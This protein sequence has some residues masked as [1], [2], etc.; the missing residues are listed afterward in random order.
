MK[1]YNSI[2]EFCDDDEVHKKLKKFFKNYYDP[3]LAIREGA[4]PD[5]VFS[6]GSRNFGKSWNVLI[7]VLAYFI[8]TDKPFAYVR[9]WQDDLTANGPCLFTKMATRGII[10]DLF[11]A[12]GDSDR[13]VYDNIVYYRRAWYFC[14]E[15]EN[16]KTIK[17]EK[18]LGIGFSI[19]SQQRYKSGGYDEFSM[20]V[21]DEAISENGYC[22][23]EFRNF[24]NLC[25][26]LTRDSDLLIFL[27]GNTVDLFCP[28]FMEMGFENVEKMKPGDMWITV[29]KGEDDQEFKEVIEY[30]EAKVKRKTDKYSA[31]GNKTAKMISKGEWE[32]DIY[33]RLPVEY[34]KEDIIYS[35]YVLNK[36]KCLKCDIVLKDELTFTFVYEWETTEDFKPLYRRDNE[37]IFTREPR[38]EYYIRNNIYRTKDKIGSSILSYI[39]DNNIYYDNNYVGAI[40]NDFIKN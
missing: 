12:F 25:V 7:L 23:N 2:Y 37:I 24:L 11:L 39:E 17:Y 18:P 20:I 28:Y 27:I 33:P 8:C 15:Q 10:R 4:K 9:R 19:N 32:F 21:Y 34:D 40:F 26:T 38:P 36:N 35:Y 29:L 6:F 16:G 30:A 13:P 3:V 22:N 31:F 1:Q 14:I 5:L